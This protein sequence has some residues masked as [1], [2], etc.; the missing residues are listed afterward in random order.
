[1]HSRILHV[2]LSCL[3]SCHLVAATVSNDSIN[4]A[5]QDED[6]IRV[7]LIT[8]GPGNEVYS[9]YGHS[10]IRLQCPTHQLDYCFTF[11][12]A[13][14]PEEE[15]KFLFSTAKAGFI[16]AE[17]ET[18]FKN[19]TAKGRSISEQQL[20]LRPAEEQQLW[21]MLDQE[22]AR[23]AHWDYSFLKTNCSSM[24]VWV[25]EKALATC[26]ETI[27]YGRVPEPVKGTY[28][29]LLDYISA[30]APWAH[31]F[32]NLRMGSKGSQ[33]GALNDKLA[34]AL[35]QE[36]WTDAA[37][38]DSAAVLRPM[39]AGPLL[40]IA[41]Q[42]LQM[43]RTLVTPVMALVISIIIIIVSIIIKKKLMKR[44]FTSNKRLVLTAALALTATVGAWAGGE[45]WYAYNVQIDAYPTG[46]GL[47]YADENDMEAY[48]PAEGAEFKQTVNVQ[49]TS[50]STLLNAFAQNADGWHLLGFAKDE[51]DFEGN[52]IFVD[53]IAYVVDEWTG[54]A[55]LSLVGETSTHWDDEQQSEVSD[56]SL[57]VAGLMPLE[58]NNYFRAIFTHAYATVAPG[59][60]Y[61]AKVKVDK[62]AN[63]IG[64]KVTFS[65]EPLSQYTTFVNWTKD[66]EVVSTNPTME[67]TVSAV[68]EYVANFTDSR[69]ITVKFPEMGGYVP[70]FSAFS[71]GLDNTGVY[72]CSPAFYEDFE[73]TCL[74]DSVN[75][76]GV[77]VSHL[78]MTESTYQ[79]GGMKALLLY[80]FGEVTLV[81]NDTVE[82]EEPYSTQLFKW[83]DAS[84][85]AVGGLDQSQDKYYVYN[86]EQQR[87]DLITDG[88]IA[89]NSLYM[90]M[91]DSLMAEG[92]S[93]PA[94]IYLDEESDPAAIKDAKIQKTTVKKGIY[95][96]SGRKMDAI[97]REGIYVFDGKKVVYRKK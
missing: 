70:F 6:F 42:T 85:L 74:V 15:L 44:L 73:N 14:K 88:S 64:D 2:L 24:C 95:D 56:D 55:S 66:G 90:V 10:A 80:G 45:D 39:F 49:Y 86:Q 79:T 22:M 46:A 1:M 11:E 58:P 12:M 53:S 37:I 59:Y 17:T 13:L 65:A 68:E 76:E 77:R 96:L 29:D 26:G 92:L 54:L 9:L 30:D 23:G 63:N 52:R 7:S 27:V 75:T 8:V 31:L 82:A 43:R 38:Q 34:P 3:I 51:I 67:V 78:S 32:W 81:P 25:I 89:A 19:Y 35:L 33:Q 16:A 36:A 87:F 20:N 91:P 4:R 84:G 21:R 60:E 40:Q 83:T 71:Y 97:S 28:R 94:V 93:A 69:N 47:V 61:L 50:K 41:P 72:A 18:F 5:A 48:E 62:L 57:T